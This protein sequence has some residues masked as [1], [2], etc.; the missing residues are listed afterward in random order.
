[1]CKYRRFKMIDLIKNELWKRGELGYKLWDQQKP[2]YDKIRG[3]DAGKAHN[4]VMLCAR[5]FGKSFLGALL[6]VEDCIKYPD[7][8]VLIVGPTIKQTID[9]VYQGIRKIQVDAPQNIIRRSKSESRWYVGE[10]ELV[11]GGFD[12]QNATRQRGKTLLKVYIEELVD[13][14]PDDYDDAIRSD[15]GPALTHSP[16]GQIIY[17]TTLPKIPDH[18]FII[19]TIP[20]AKLAGSYFCYT[21]DDNTQLS[22]AQYDAAIKRAGGINSVECRR[23]LFCEIARDRSVLVVPSFE[24]DRHVKDDLEFP[25][26]GNYQVTTDWGGVRD[27]TCAILHVYDYL[28]DRFLVLDEVVHDAN[29]AT[30]TI[31]ADIG[32]MIARYEKPIH[33]HIADVPGQLQ[34][35][36]RE[37]HNYNVMIPPKDDWKAACNNLDVGFLED[38]ILMHSRCKFVIENCNSGTFNKTKTDFERTRAL[39]H[40]D[41]LAA[42]MYGFRTQ[43]RENPWPKRADSFSQDHYFVIPQKDPMEELAKAIQP[44]KFGLKKKF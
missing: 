41:G 35:D 38:K 42:L 44:R 24:K 18:P 17:L 14:R 23:E 10:S 15:I 26:F 16:D 13:S 19:D 5:Q 4:I 40:C 22:K 3:L 37:L 27:K 11:V 12:I 43:N 25:R 39:G 21:I 33:Q 31:L 8:T 29:T 7:S 34:I 2:I 36:L 28:L 30:S 20:E 6:A 9:I 1:M 32:S